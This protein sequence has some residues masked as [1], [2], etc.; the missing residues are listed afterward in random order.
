MIKK[1]P[2]EQ[3]VTR[4]KRVRARVKGTAKCP[5]LCVFRSQ[6]HLYAQL[7]DDMKGTVI[8]AISDLKDVKKGAPITRASAMGKQI[9]KD[10]QAKGITKIVFDRG[11]YKYHGNIKALAE[12]AREGGLVF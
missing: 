10:A 6:K 2:R 12:G 3:R 11:G 9:A 1:T 4:H 8:T 5:R 7:V